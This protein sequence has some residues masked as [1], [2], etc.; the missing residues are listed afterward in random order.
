MSG[1]SAG[2]MARLAAL[3][4]RVFP[5]RAPE[6]VE[7]LGGMTNFT[8]AV[9]VAGA[10]YTFRLPGEGTEKLINRQDEKISNELACAVGIDAQLRY[11]DAATGEKVSDYIENA[12]TLSPKSLREKRNIVDAARLLRT[13][14]GCGQDTG[15]P[16]EVFDMAAR[17]EGFIRDN[18]GSFYD[19]YD[20]VRRQVMAVKAEVDR[21]A[22]PK[23]PCHNDPLCENW[24]RSGEKLYLVDW[25]YAGM[26]DPMWDLAD[27]SIEA[28]YD[29][30]MDGL[31]LET[32]FGAAPPPQARYRFD[33]NKVYLDFLWSLWGKTRAPF[34][35]EVMEQYAVNR[36]RRLKQSLAL[37]AAG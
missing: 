4:A 17:Y 28:D 1:V 30:D 18:G 21:L 22:A 23:A 3:T 29:A 14:H 37:I 33:A 32:Y 24:V 15:V 9:T 13:L 26:N 2:D 25:E 6:A 16:F 20:E 7:R 5:G 27:V 8:Y 34:D 19:D 35:G 31:L 12:E 10:H 36:Y 11:F